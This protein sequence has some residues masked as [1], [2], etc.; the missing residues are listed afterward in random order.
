MSAYFIPIQTAFIA[1]ILLGFVLVIPWLIYSYRKYGFLSLWASIV[2]YS[3]MYYMLSALFLVLLPLPESRNTCAYQS[4]DTV[5]Y[6]LIPFSF[7][8]EI[9]RAHV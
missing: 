8:T 7:V 4:A 9:G 3:F 5:Y 1:F 2:A 6:S